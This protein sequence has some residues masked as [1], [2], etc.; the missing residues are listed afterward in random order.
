MIQWLLRATVHKLVQEALEAQAERVR[1]VTS[2]IASTDSNACQ[3]KWK[4]WEERQRLTRMKVGTQHVVGEFIHMERDCSECGDTQRR[5][6]QV[7]F[8]P[9]NDQSKNSK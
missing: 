8:C 2:A 5:V 7:D 3:H 1:K 9:G 6:D 4:T